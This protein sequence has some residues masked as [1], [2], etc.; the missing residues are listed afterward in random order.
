MR[1]ILLAALAVCLASPLHANEELQQQLSDNTKLCKVAADAN[2]LADAL[3]FC[4]KA[5]AIQSVP[6]NLVNL[7]SA[8]YMHGK[9]KEAK[10]NFIDAM[11]I[12]P[13]L[14]VAHFNLGRVYEICDQSQAQA[15]EQYEMA[16][17][18]GDT[19][20]SAA[21]LEMVPKKLYTEAFPKQ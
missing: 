2:N 18:L 4:G 14:A 5:N 11:N 13:T 19:T 8:L 9:C 7:G 6:V 20:A 16:Q 17:S 21:I 10:H 12:E 1:M 15:L 3:I